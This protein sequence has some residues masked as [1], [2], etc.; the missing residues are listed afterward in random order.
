M[1]SS[2][3]YKKRRETTLMGV[4]RSHLHKKR[5][6]DFFPLSC[7]FVWSFF[8]GSEFSVRHAPPLL[9]AWLR[10]Q[11]QGSSVCGCVVPQLPHRP[12]SSSS[13]DWASSKGCGTTLFAEQSHESVL[14]AFPRAR[15]LPRRPKEEWSHMSRASKAETRCCPLDVS[16]P[17]W[18]EEKKASCRTVA[19]AE[20]VEDEGEEARGVSRWRGW[21][22]GDREKRGQR[23]AFAWANPR[24]VWNFSCC[25]GWTQ[26]RRYFPAYP[27]AWQ[28]CARPLSLRQLTERDVGW[29]LCRCG[30]LAG[31]MSS[32]GD[33]AEFPFKTPHP[34]HYWHRPDQG[35]W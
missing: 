4:R 12:L 2:R 25:R 31:E 16:L 9:C 1:T 24:L 11:Q 30:R 34:Q 18:V 28:P 22:L 6:S 29:Q 8:C 21:R 19:L 13:V 7:R 27:R 3:W 15:L 5:T 32:L 20:E 23:T 33:E 17:G 26:A 35:R 14:Q 10:V